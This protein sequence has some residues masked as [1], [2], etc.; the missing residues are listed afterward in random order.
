MKTPELGIAAGFKAGM[1]LI[2]GDYRNQYE[3][4][5]PPRSCRR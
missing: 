5:Y 3:H 1:D 2:C 4:R